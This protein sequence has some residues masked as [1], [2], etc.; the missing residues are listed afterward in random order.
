MG[1]GGGELRG[2]SQYV[3]ILLHAIEACIEAYQGTHSLYFSLLHFCMPGIDACLS[4]M[5]TYQMLLKLVLRPSEALILFLF[6]CCIS[7]GMF[8]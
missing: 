1:G 4:G 5:E 6:P 7:V 8:W 3:L 2:L